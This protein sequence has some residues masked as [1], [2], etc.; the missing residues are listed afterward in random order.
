MNIGLKGEVE[1]VDG[2]GGYISALVFNPQTRIATHLVVRP[3]SHDNQE[4]LI[5]LALIERATDRD[6][7]LLNCLMEDLAKQEPFKHMVATDSP[8]MGGYTG[9]GMM[10]AEMHGGLAAS[11]FNY[12]AAEAPSF[13]EA[14]AIPAEQIAIRHGVPVRATDDE[15]GELDELFVNKESGE[16]THLVFKEGHLWRKHH[17]IVSMD[18]VDR[19]SEEVVLLK[20]SKD[21]VEQL[22]KV[23]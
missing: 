6:G 17:A 11:D 5:P 14:E 13:I 22:P 21:A 7:I 23:K 3:K 1:C 4:Y 18:E 19:V 2:Y 8:G 16:V 9:E 20:L 10:A 12:R 15:V